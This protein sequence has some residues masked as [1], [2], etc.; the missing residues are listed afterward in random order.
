MLNDPLDGVVGLEDW[1]D[2]DINPEPEV[3]DIPR[4][5]TDGFADNAIVPEVVIVPP[6]RFVPAVTLVTVP[7]PLPQGEPASSSW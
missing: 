2:I 5:V 3:P 4:L 1:F 7:L 6:V